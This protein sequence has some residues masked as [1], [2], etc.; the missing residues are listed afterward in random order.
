MTTREKLNEAKSTAYALAY[1]YSEDYTMQRAK[2]GCGKLW[3]E[4]ME[5]AQA[6]TEA[7]DRILEQGEN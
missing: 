3:L 5:Y 1:K 6:V 7:V 2:M 4:A